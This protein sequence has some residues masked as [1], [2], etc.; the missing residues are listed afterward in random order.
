MA[1]VG[2]IA[3]PFEVIK[4]RT[5][6]VSYRKIGGGKV[7]NCTHSD[8]TE[9]TEMK[10]HERKRCNGRSSVADQRST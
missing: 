3:G 10:R 5:I 2:D 7:Y 9:Y 8:W 1:K 6:C 4:V